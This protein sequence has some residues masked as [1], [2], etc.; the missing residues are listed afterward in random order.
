MTRYYIT[1]TLLL[2]CNGLCGH[3][4]IFVVFKSKGLYRVVFAFLSISKLGG[5]FFIIIY[6]MICSVHISKSKYIF[7]E[8][9]FCNTVAFLPHLFF[10][11]TDGTQVSFVFLSV[12]DFLS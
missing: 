3:V 9:V 7:A 11:F 4:L 10:I 12:I 1:V 8:T 2:I 5:F 6:F